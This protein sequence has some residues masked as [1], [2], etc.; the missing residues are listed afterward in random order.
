MPFDFRGKFPADHRAHLDDFNDEGGAGGVVWLPSYLS[1]RALRD[2]GTLVRIDYLLAG[3]GD[4]LDEAARH[5][6]AIE[7]EQ[8][9]AVLRSQQSALH[10]R[11]RTCI[12]CAYGIRPDQDSCLGTLVA[13]EDHL[14]PLDGTFRPQRPVGATMKDALDALLDRLFEHRYPAHPIF[15][16]E[17]RA[18]ALKQVLEQVQK[19]AAEPQQRLF[20]IDP[21]WWTP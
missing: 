20:G 17:V 4:R 5:L 9:R 14:F 18:L 7:R 15:E 12:E 21:I 10:Q 16:Q 3:A 13:T 2:L 6:S 8:A 11:I 1:D 19:A